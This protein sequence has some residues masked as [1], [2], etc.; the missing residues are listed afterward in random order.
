MAQSGS[1]SNMSEESAKPWS[2]IHESA[3]FPSAPTWDGTPGN[4]NIG[5]L[6]LILMT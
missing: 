3:E 1:Q 4:L 2:S 6:L 5:K